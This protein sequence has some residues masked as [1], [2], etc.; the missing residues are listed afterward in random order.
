MW[1]W[2]SWGGLIYGV[3]TWSLRLTVVRSNVCFLSCY[4]LELIG[5]RQT[6]T[7]SLHSILGLINQDVNSLFTIRA[8]RWDVNGGVVAIF[9]GFYSGLEVGGGFFLAV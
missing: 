6:E 3:E 7:T 8:K 9:F 4:D 2:Q 1:V 5:D